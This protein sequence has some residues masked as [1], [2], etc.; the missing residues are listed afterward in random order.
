MGK[1]KSNQ[2]NLRLPL[3]LLDELEQVANLT[4]LDEQEIVKVILR[5]FVRQVSGGEKLE[6]PFRFVSS[7][8]AGGAAKVESTTQKNVGAPPADE[9]PARRR[10]SHVVASGSAGNPSS[11][12][13]HGLGPEN[14][15]SLRLGAD[16]P[17]SVRSGK[18]TLV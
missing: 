2:L 6:F 14:L 15:D 16:A 13:M 9:K 8:I 4:G 10:A 17:A 12:S 18:G 3:E 7:E 1:R 5:S 11:S